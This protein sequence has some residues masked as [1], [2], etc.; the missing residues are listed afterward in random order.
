MGRKGEQEVETFERSRRKVFD[1]R[2]NEVLEVGSIRNTDAPRRTVIEE[3]GNRSR[4]SGELRTDP[5][6]KNVSSEGVW[7]FSTI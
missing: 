4:T 3:E 2:E 1:T 6:V 5:I 7:V